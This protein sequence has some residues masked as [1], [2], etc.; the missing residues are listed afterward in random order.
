MNINLTWED[1]ATG[2]I[3]DRTVALPITL[4][5]TSDNAISLISSEV[6]RQH[7]RLEET[8]EGQVRVTDL[9]STNGILVNQEETQSAVLR[10]GDL[11]TVGPFNITVIIDP[12]FEQEAIPPGAVVVRWEHTPD[13]RTEDVILRPPFTIGRATEG[14]LRLVSDEVSRL[15]ARVL[16]EDDTLVI[17]DEGSSNGTFVN[18]V[19]VPRAAVGPDDEI[20]LGQFRLTITPYEAGFD[21]SAPVSVRTTSTVHIDIAELRELLAEEDEDEIT[22]PVPV[23]GFP[24]PAFEQEVVDPAALAGYPSDETVFLTIGGGLGS[25]VFVD[26]LTIY[27]ARTEDIVS[28]GFDELPYGRFLRLCLNSQIPLHERLRSDSGSTPDNIWGFPSYAVREMWGDVTSGRFGHALGLVWNMFG[29]PTLVAT[30]TPISGKV[31]DSLDREANRIG[32][33]DMHRMGKVR[34]IR[35]TTDGRYVVAY[36]TTDPANREKR[37]IFAQYVH[38]AVGYPALRFLPDLQAYREETGDFERVVNAYEEHDHI[39]EDLAKNGGTVQIRGRG[40]VASRILQRIYETR[41]RNPNINVLHLMRSRNTQGQRYGL[42]HRP[43][44]HHWEFQPFNWPKAAWGG[45]LRVRLERAGDEQRAELLN[46]WGGTTTADRPDW[47]RIV[48]GGVKEGW[49]LIHFGTVERVEPGANG[50]LNT[51]VRGRSAIGEMLTLTA[52]YIIDSTGLVSAIDESP[53]LRDLVE[54]HRLDR[55]AL[56]RLKVSNDFELTGMRS[57]SGRMYASGVATLGGPYA[58]V[59]SFQGMQYSDYR[60]VD[61]LA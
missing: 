48:D 22:A 40:I 28:I 46:D 23:S 4:G 1:P 15:H 49:Y 7:A 19:Q 45:D 32:W 36:S 9:N 10:S 43:V 58:A 12:V 13:G 50:R 5:R 56:G 2:Q 53:L 30:Y 3:E 16:R 33:S 61:D 60:I 31:F 21:F 34:A 11:L 52:D 24:P 14:D 37:V 8:G 38:V 25:F 20:Q 18:G 55:N 29:E 54:H 59:D 42:S 6:S 27:G 44:E 26:Y 39:Y 47:R 57:G 17:V 35:R 51:V 41:A